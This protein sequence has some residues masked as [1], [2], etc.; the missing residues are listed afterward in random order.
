M[1]YMGSDIAARCDRG[2]QTRGCYLVMS[3]S[4][5]DGVQEKILRALEQRTT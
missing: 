3:N 5:F 1:M 4:G 2:G